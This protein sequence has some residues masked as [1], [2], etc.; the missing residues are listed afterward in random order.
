MVSSFIN[1]SLCGW[2]L[3]LCMKVA[4]ARIPA[5]SW[6]SRSF[7]HPYSQ[8]KWACFYSVKEETFSRVAP[9]FWKRIPPLR[10]LHDVG[11]PSFLFNAPIANYPKAIQ[12]SDERIGGRVILAFVRIGAQVYRPRPVTSLTITTITTIT[13]TI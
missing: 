8:R 2:C 1:L 11:P 13:K 4:R 12:V 3:L 5:N 7:P 6:F 9:C 10:R